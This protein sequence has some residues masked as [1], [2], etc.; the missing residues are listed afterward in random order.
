MVKRIFRSNAGNLVYYRFNGGN[1]NVIILYIHGLIPVKPLFV[2]VFT[3]QHTE[4]SLSEY[5]WIIPYLIGFGESEKPDELEVYTM[6]NQGQYL[7]ELLL[8]E[9]VRDVVI[10][11]HSMG[12]P[13]AKTLID[14]IQNQP[15]GEIQVRGLFYLEGNLD[16]NDTFLSSTIAQYPFEEFKKK[17]HE[18]VEDMINQ[19]NLDYSL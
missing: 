14:R 5:S 9:K 11:A 19:I 4:Y 7:Y 3:R 15:N 10:M 12:G 16:K 17:Y 13:I 18:W 6:E 2:Q 8:F 1:E